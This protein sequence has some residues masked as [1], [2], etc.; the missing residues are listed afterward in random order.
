MVHR[1]ILK[2]SIRGK[3]EIT[4]KSLNEN[5]L[6]EEKLLIY[7]LIVWHCT[8]IIYKICNRYCV[9]FLTRTHLFDMNRKK[10]G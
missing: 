6:L 4:V 8:T 1:H 3:N 10:V 2:I 5:F 7:F 9:A